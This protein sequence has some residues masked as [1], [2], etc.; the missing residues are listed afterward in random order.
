MPEDFDRDAADSN[1]QQDAEDI[2]ALDWT[3]VLTD[4]IGRS[5]AVPLSHAAPVYPQVNAIPRRATFLD[6]AELSEALF[7][8][9]SLP[10][11]DF[12]AV[13]S[14][15]DVDNLARLEFVFDRS[16]RGAIMLDDISLSD[17][18]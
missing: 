18:P 12:L 9:I 11:A 5:A 1:G 14:Q 3:V 16:E 6:G 15:L 7:Q 17:T 10:S 8:R 4:R 2:A 13:E